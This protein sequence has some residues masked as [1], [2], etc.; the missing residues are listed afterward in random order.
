MN[1]STTS[2]Y[3]C[4]SWL[5]ISACFRCHWDVARRRLGT[6]FYFNCVSRK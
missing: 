2:K 1:L 5:T 6:S 3:I 4:K